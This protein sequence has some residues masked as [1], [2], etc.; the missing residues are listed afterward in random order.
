MLLVNYSASGNHSETVPIHFI[1][2]PFKNF[3]YSRVN[4]YG[5]V[6]SRTVNLAES[7]WTTYEDLS[8]NSAAILEL[9]PIET[10]QK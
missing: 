1:N 10:I 3:K 8:N 5:G 2:I 7:N 4:F 6:T 9:T